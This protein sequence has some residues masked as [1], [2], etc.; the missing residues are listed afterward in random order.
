[1][2]FE[3]RFLSFASPLPLESPD[4]NMKTSPRCSPH[5]LACLSS[6]NPPAA[7]QKSRR[8]RRQMLRTF[9]LKRDLNRP[10][11][12]PLV[13]PPLGPHLGTQRGGRS[14][15]R[16]SDSFR[17][18]VE[19]EPELETPQHQPPKAATPPSPL[20]K[21]TPKREQAKPKAR[22][23]EMNLP[24]TSQPIRPAQTTPTIKMNFFVCSGQL[25]AAGISH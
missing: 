23:S 10:K 4:S 16:A 11:T 13:R 21:G 5:W 2:K 12:R 3:I 9:A 24:Y 22:A 14:D 18:I 17:T 20:A 25:Q 15:M 1:M 6:I 7:Q 19:V 8:R